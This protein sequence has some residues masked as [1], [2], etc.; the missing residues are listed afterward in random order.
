MCWL[1][2]MSGNYLPSKTRCVDPQLR[3]EIEG[4]YMVIIVNIPS[5][6]KR[7]HL[8]P[9]VKTVSLVRRLETVGA[10]V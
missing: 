1:S 8:W 5:P 2:A 4:D 6:P 7:E 9:S 3:R 10:Y